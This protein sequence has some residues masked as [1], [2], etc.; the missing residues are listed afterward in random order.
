MAEGVGASANGGTQTQTKGGLQRA[1]ASV[2]RTSRVPKERR[3]FRCVSR[4]KV[5][6]ALTVTDLTLARDFFLLVALC[7]GLAC[8][9]VCLARPVMTSMFE[10]ITYLV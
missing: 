5:E 8:A 4:T 10:S 1:K 6:L 7:I 2:Q 9:L 3:E